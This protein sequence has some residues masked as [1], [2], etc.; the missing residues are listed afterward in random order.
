M[1]SSVADL[2]AE[3]NRLGVQLKADGD[4]LGFG[5]RGL[6]PPDLADRIR[7]HKAELLALV[8]QRDELIP[9]CTADG[10]RGWIRP[11]YWA[12][13]WAGMTDWRE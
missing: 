9:Y 6:V 11:D 12:D 13:Y 10:R 1:A 3:L 5:P 2:L 4:R 7:A 8:R